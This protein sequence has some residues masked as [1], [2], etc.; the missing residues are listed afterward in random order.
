[1][2]EVRR[3]KSRG[4][5]PVKMGVSVKHLRCGPDWAVASEQKWSRAKRETESKQ[6]L[7]VSGIQGVRER[8]KSRVSSKPF[9]AVTHRS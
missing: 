3:V 8:V 2:Q 5:A 4:R 1:M 9:K 7:A 6:D